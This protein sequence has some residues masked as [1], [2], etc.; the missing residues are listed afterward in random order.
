MS[1]ARAIPDGDAMT[2]SVG[3][4]LT[5]LGLAAYT[6]RFIAG[7]LT[8]VHDLLSMTRG[9]LRALGVNNRQHVDTLLDSIN[10][11]SLHQH[12]HTTANNTRSAVIDRV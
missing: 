12:V 6:G 9:D 2:S 11:I 5:S 8:A 7:G 3:D 1:V 10:S 4:W